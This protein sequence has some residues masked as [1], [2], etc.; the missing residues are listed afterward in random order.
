MKK[1]SI[2]IKVAKPKAMSS[3]HMEEYA[4]MSPA[5]LKKHMGEEKKLV[6]AKIAK[7]KAK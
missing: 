3:E 1:L 7:K 2:K 4:K 6:K 5:M